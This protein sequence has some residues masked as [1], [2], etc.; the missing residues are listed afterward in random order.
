MTAGTEA[1]ARARFHLR[2]DEGKK[3]RWAQSTSCTDANAET[4][5]HRQRRP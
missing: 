4:G 1:S 5:I 2:P 3:Y